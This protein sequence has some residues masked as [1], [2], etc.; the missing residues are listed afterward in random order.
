M[1]STTSTLDA[2][3]QQAKEIYARLGKLIEDIKAVGY[4][5]DT[6]SIHDVKA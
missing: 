3:H 1:R 2:N 5:L 4:V 6:D